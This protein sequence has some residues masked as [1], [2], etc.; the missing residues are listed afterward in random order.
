M[1]AGKRRWM[2]EDWFCGLKDF[3]GSHC[4]SPIRVFVVIPRD[5]EVAGSTAG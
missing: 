3:V 5:D 1:S 2:L 4:S